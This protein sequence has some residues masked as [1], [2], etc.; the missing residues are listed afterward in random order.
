MDELRAQGGSAL[1]DPAGWIHPLSAA[2]YAAA[3]PEFAGQLG[4]QPVTT[5]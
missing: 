4:G 2:S 1:P 3:V 5:W